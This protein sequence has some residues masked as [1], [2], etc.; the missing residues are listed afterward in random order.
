MNSRL[1]LDP[2]WQKV[3]GLPSQAAAAP[4]TS[5]PPP[6]SR[7]ASTTVY[8]SSGRTPPGPD[9]EVVPSAYQAR[10]EPV[11]IRK[12]LSRHVWASRVAHPGD[13]LHPFSQPATP[14]E[15]VR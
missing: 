11:A 14:M 8:F 10:G 6:P 9:W 2:V 12:R 15:N 13:P 7:Q 3:L 4:M 1:A 5:T